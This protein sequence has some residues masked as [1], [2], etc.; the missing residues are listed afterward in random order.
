MRIP[1][2]FQKKVKSRMIT[3][4]EL[5]FLLTKLYDK[6]RVAAAMQGMDFIEEM[7]TVKEPYMSSESE[8]DDWIAVIDVVETEGEDEERPKL[9]IIAGYYKHGKARIS[10]SYKVWM[11]IAATRPLD[12]RE[13]LNDYIR[14]HLLS[15][16]A[17]TA[18]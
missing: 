1:I 18:L 7:P 2:L 9:G 12:P 4:E 3:I 17:H 8:R 6:Y 13:S 16:R 10:E 15:E 5:Q 11:G 14:D